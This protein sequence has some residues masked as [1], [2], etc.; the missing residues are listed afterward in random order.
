LRL[1]TL[2]GVRE[3]NQMSFLKRIFRTKAQKGVQSSVIEDNSSA[4]PHPASGDV[5]PFRM[6]I[7]DRF[8]LEGDDRPFVVTGKVEGGTLQ[9]GD[10]V[11]IV[12]KRNMHI[13]AE[14]VAIEHCRKMIAIASVGN[15]VGVRI[16]SPTLASREDF[17]S[18]IKAGDILCELGSE[19]E[20]Q[21]APSSGEPALA[22]SALGEGRIRSSLTPPRFAI[23]AVQLRKVNTNSTIQWKTT[24]D[25]T[26]PGEYKAVIEEVGAAELDRL[27]SVYP[28]LKS[29]CLEITKALHHPVDS[30][31]DDFREATKAAIEEAFRAL[32]GDQQ[33]VGVDVAS[34]HGLVK[35]LL[36]ADPTQ[37][38]EA[39]NAT[40]SYAKLG[41]PDGL[42]AL[43]QAIRSKY[44][45]KDII[46]FR[47]LER[48]IAMKPGEDE[49]SY[50]MLIDLAKRKML[51]K[52]NPGYVQELYAKATGLLYDGIQILRE[53]EKTNDDDQ[54]LAFQLIG[55]HYIV[56]RQLSALER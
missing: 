15:D 13:E 51:W 3:K 45:G 29:Y 9:S 46:S 37:R 34:A 39:I 10:R 18:F 31:A 36:S 8:F 4:A 42:I 33:G 22:T 2:F 56:A 27:A 26:L 50:R 21:F 24:T 32:H 16:S 41:M 11:V 20:T 55:Q 7:G 14:V 38:N 54:I 12:N 1:L 44:S 53:I 43:E 47:Q 25:H 23:V 5:L 30:H 28:Q 17:Y 19:L 52:T 48:F 40:G 6:T 35:Q 49:R